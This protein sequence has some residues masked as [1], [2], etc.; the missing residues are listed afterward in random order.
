MS[1][2]F[3]CKR[4]GHCCHG[5]STVSIQKDEQG[6]IA[7]YL[8]LEL[9]I[10]LNKFCVKKGARIEMRVTDG[11]CVFYGGDGLCAIHPVKPA[12]CRIWPL[13][14]SILDDPMAWEA[15]KADCPGFP[16]GSAYEKICELIRS[17]DAED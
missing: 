4:C 8:D 14:R 15:I 1:R 17:H 6:R 12:P 13:H 3:E 5:E 7:A 11:H 9:D 10:F 16:E 2:L